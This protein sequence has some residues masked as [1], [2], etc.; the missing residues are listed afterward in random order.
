MNNNT[1]HKNVTVKSEAG[2]HARPAD[3]LVRLTKQ[4]EST[5]LIEHRGEKIDCESILSIL[6][7]GAT[8]GTELM[9]HVTGDDAEHAI[10]ALDRFF[11]SGF[12]ETQQLGDA[13]DS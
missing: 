10:S 5:V 12:Q 3:L 11:E 8:Q 4:F 6:T 9:L 2:L 7:L 1:L 13:V